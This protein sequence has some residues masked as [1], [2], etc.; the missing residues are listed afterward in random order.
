MERRLTAILA[1]DVTGQWRRRPH[2]HT[3]HGS[4][5]VSGGAL[6]KIA[7]CHRADSVSQCWN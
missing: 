4:V 6:D 3:L 5:A 1:A 7:A 2:I